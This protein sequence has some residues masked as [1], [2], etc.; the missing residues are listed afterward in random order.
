MSDV[1]KAFHQV[2]IALQDRDVLRFLWIDDA[3]SPG[4]E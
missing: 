3:T 2:S 1:E 4:K